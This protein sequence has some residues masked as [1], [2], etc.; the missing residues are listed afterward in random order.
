MPPRHTKSRKNE[1]ELP[2]Y[3]QGQSGIPASKMMWG[4]WDLETNPGS[5][6]KSDLPRSPANQSGQEIEECDF[7]ISYFFSIPVTEDVLREI[8]RAIE[9][10]L[11]PEIRRILDRYLLEK[12]RG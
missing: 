1:K 12:R 4:H 11:A 10:R 8:E 3:I 9:M 6:Y 2:L 7:L 5:G